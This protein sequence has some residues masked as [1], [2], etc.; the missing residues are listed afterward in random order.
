[1][2]DGTAKSIARGL[3][4]DLVYGVKSLAS[5][6]AGLI[7]LCLT[8]IAALIIVFFVL[9]DSHYWAWIVLGLL[10]FGLGVRFGKLL[11]MESLLG[12][13]QLFIGLYLLLFRLV[14][15]LVKRLIIL[16]F[17][18]KPTTPVQALQRY[19]RLINIEAFEA[20][21]AMLPQGSKVWK[22]DEGEAEKRLEPLLLG[23][24]HSPASY[25]LFW[26]QFVGYSIQ[27]DALFKLVIDS[28]DRWQTSE[29]DGD[30]RIVFPVS[31]SWMQ[32]RKGTAPR[33]LTISYRESVL[34]SRQPER[35]CVN[36]PAP[37]IV[38]WS[39]EQFKTLDNDLENDD[40]QCLAAQ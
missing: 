32:P 7:W 11:A 40:M 30:W 12:L 16:G 25:A 4:R 13:A 18:V 24:F 29:S 35:W 23:A 22:N 21:Y 37:A 9:A 39:E 36:W 5:G 17:D 28:A 15:D 1:M 19:C 14:F 34:I 26:S 31:L 27:I 33:P 6:F 10:A 8:L 2:V 38:S 3:R 20:A